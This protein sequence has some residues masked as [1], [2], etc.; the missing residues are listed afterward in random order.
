[1]RRQWIRRWLIVALFA[2][3]MAWVE[4]AVV[5]YL[6]TLL[7]RI[8]PYQNNPLPNFARFNSVEQIREAATLVMLTTVGWLA[9]E[10]PK[11]RFGF[12][13]IAFG[14]WD[15]F[16]YIFLRIICGWPKTLFDWDVLFLLPLPWWGPGL[17]PML[18]A[19]LMVAFGTL[20]TQP[21][22]ACLELWPGRWSVASNGIGI[23]LA[24]YV[25]MES[26]IHAPQITAEALEKIRP[27]QFNW[28]LFGIAFA[29]MLA[30]MIEV[31][32]QCRRRPVLP[33][34]VKP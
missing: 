17:L 25:F 11:K 30:P 32:A 27:E 26:A 7:D 1:M 33:Q 10:N 2:V 13:L 24:L 20:V 23:L 34:I 16:Y 22:E 29:L 19:L 9:G 8:D 6:R 15:T 12:T 21:K 14:I 4:S 28:P 31:G 18:T 3:A 5:V